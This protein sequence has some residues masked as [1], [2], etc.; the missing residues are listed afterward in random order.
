MAQKKH[1]WKRIGHI[2]NHTWECTNCGC[3]KDAKKLFSTE[4]RHNGETTETAPNCEVK[5]E[6]AKEGWES[7]WEIVNAQIKNGV[8]PRIWEIMK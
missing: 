1:K 7:D 5:Q 8:N 6:P 3:I 4:Y 2:Y